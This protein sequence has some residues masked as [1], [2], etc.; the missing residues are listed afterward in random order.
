LASPLKKKKPAEQKKALKK[1]IKNFDILFWPEDFQII[2]YCDL[3]QN[4]TI[5]SRNEQK[6]CD[7]N[8]LYK[9]ILVHIVLES[10]MI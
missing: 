3:Q 4:E 8:I 6:K 9:Q 5:F 7:E 10:C 2:F 1:F